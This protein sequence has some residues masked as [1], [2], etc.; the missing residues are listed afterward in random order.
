VH[1]AFAL[2]DT[3]FV[4][5]Y[6]NSTARHLACRFGSFSAEDKAITFTDPTVFESAHLSFA[7]LFTRA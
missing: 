6:S 5:A 4:V 7:L 1:D 2:S 3:T